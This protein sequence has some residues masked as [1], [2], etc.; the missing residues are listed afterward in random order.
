MPI[1]IVE[2]LCITL[3]TTFDAMLKA[4]EAATAPIQALI[5]QLDRLRDVGAPF[6]DVGRSIDDAILDIEANID[7]IVPKDITDLA[8]FIS[9]CPFL[10]KNPM[11]KNAS[12]VAL[13]LGPHLQTGVRLSI[14][15][16]ANLREFEIA[17]LT[18]SIA[19]L[20]ETLG[21]ELSFEQLDDIII[22]LEAMC[23]YD[24]TERL[25]K[26]TDLKTLLKVGGTGT[27]NP[28]A[29][30]LDLGYAQVPGFSF[31]NATAAQS[32]VDEIV[33]GATDALTSFAESA[34]PSFF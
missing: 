25:A 10:N 17:S 7:D 3:E 20:Y 18:N 23:G 27:F 14:N 12:T 29:L 15:T 11:L 33:G 6:A 24:V 28:T 31:I 19:S 16:I 30:L 4:V 8:D 9:R 2:P 32:A 5:D 13:L 21:I 34:K 26:L 1:S 22:C